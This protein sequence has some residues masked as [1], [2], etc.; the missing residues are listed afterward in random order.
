MDISRSDKV[1]AGSALL[2][3]L[4]PVLI[5][6]GRLPD[7]VATHWGPGG[8]PDGNMTKPIFLLLS[9]FLWGILWAAYLLGR[10]KAPSTWQ[11][12][13]VLGF[14][15]AVIFVNASIVESN[16][17]VRSW[18]SAESLNGP[19]VLLSFLGSW[20]VFGLLTYAVARR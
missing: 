18:A 2:L 19:L 7:P 9:V 3:I 16:L 12:P 8:R 6:W 10:A 17:D 11:S 15:G 4:I 13:F 20:L 5:F 1:L 14:A